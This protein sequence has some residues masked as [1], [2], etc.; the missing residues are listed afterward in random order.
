MKKG[1]EMLICE[2][3][4][5]KDLYVFGHGGLFELLG[6]LATVVL[7]KIVDDSLFEAQF[8][9]NVLTEDHF[10]FKDVLIRKDQ[11]N[12][13]HQVFELLIHGERAQRINWLWVTDQVIDLFFGEFPFTGDLKDH[14][15][16]DLGKM[17][18]GFRQLY[19]YI[20]L[21]FG[22]DIHLN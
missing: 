10:T 12:A 1:L 11:F 20:K 14:F 18:V 7:N 4:F 16:F 8:D 13:R 22:D 19:K 9:G 6:C 5:K 2:I 3:W 15:A 17:F 21:L